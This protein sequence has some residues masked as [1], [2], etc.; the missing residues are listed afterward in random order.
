MY[1]QQLRKQAMNLKETKV[2]ST[3]EE[4]VREEGLMLLY[5]N[6]KKNKIHIF[7]SGEGDG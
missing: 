3:W 6:L 5:Y 4:L 2:G 7:K 1:K